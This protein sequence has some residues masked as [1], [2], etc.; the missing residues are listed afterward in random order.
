MSIELH[1]D[2]GKLDPASLCYSIYSQLYSN[3]FN[4]QDRKD[5]THPWGVVEGDDTSARLKNTAFSFAAAISG[6][7]AGEGGSDN[8]GILLGYLKKAV[9]T[10][11]EFYGQTMDLRPVLVITVSSLYIKMEIVR[12]YRSTEILG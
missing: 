7:V 3:F 10:W 1:P 4:A 11:L 8:G 2:I 12:V 9:G 5:D 6:S